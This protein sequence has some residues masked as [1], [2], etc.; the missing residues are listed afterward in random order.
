MKDSLRATRNG[1]NL[2]VNY[3]GI[4][5]QAQPEDKC[6]IPFTAEVGCQSWE[7]RHFQVERIPVAVGKTRENKLYFVPYQGKAIHQ[8][9][10][11]QQ[12]CQQHAQGQSLVTVSCMAYL[13]SHKY[14]TVV[15][16]QVL[17]FHCCE[18]RVGGASTF[19]RKI[20]LQ[21]PGKLTFSS[22]HDA[23]TWEQF[24]NR[25][26]WSC[27][28]TCVYNMYTGYGLTAMLIGGKK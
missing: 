27:T 13:V 15:V 20:G 12:R 25:G 21:P 2:N 16:L 22:V 5:P 18:V 23:G 1:C 14:I 8:S 9:L 4:W 26:N 11:E 17:Q 7:Q 19:E 6:C 24:V 10:A 3:E 28:C